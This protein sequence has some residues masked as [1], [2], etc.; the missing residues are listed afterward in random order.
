[1][2]VFS[3]MIIGFNEISIKITAHFPKQKINEIIPKFIWKD[4]SLY[5]QKNF[6]NEVSGLSVISRITIELQY[7]RVLTKDRHMEQWEGTEIPEID[8]SHMCSTDF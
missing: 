2:S 3:K 7:S 5:S 8:T 1:M 6:E 4:K